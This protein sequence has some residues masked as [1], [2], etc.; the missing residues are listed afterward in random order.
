MSRSL[1]VGMVVL[2]ALVIGIGTASAAYCKTGYSFDGDG[3]ATYPNGG[4]LWSTAYHDSDGG[5]INCYTETYNID[6]NTVYIHASGSASV[7]DRAGTGGW[8]GGTH[9]SSIVTND[10]PPGEGVVAYCYATDTSCFDSGSASYTTTGLSIVGRS[11]VSDWYNSATYSSVVVYI[12][13]NPITVYTVSGTTGCVSSV[14]L[15]QDLGG[16]YY[17]INSTTLNPGGDS[18]RFEIFDGQSYRLIFDGAYYDF[19]CDG[20]EVF[21]YDACIWVYGYTCG[22]ETIKLYKDDGGWVLVDTESQGISYSEYEMQ[23]FDGDDYL[24][25]FLDGGVVCHNETFSCTGN[26]VLIDFD[27]CTW[28]WPPSPWGPPIIIYLWAG[29]D[30]NI[31]VFKDVHGNFIENSQLA[32]YDKTDS[33]FIQ[34]WTEASEGYTLLGARFDTDHDVQLMLRTFDGIFTLDADHPANGTAIVGEES[35]IMTNWTIPIK[36]NLNVLPQDQYGAPLFDVFCGLSEYTPLDPGSFWG[37]DLSDQGYVAV[38]NCSGFS[39]CDIVAEKE[40]YTDYKV[41]ALNWTSKSAMVKDYRH[42]VV[43]EEE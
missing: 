15:L 12:S 43:M 10:N 30:Y 21:D 14:S 26:H 11:T 9:A 8:K 2:A 34:R 28:V 24:I 19:T 4:F 27:R 13:P 22:I 38:T 25:S 6:Y 32:I 3:N 17:T 18:Y 23:I 36:Y 33:Q 20:N 7:S 39:M 40:G 37:M 29:Y 31:V 41:E 42:N 1:L 35:I 5:S 16:S